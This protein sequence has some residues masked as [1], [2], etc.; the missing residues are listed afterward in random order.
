MG[1]ALKAAGPPLTRVAAAA[2]VAPAVAPANDEAL[3]L[4]RRSTVALETIAR[5]I[6]GI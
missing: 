2:L 6:G 4:L 1:R 3:S 5:C